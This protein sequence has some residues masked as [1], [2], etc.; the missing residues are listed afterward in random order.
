MKTVPTVDGPH[1]D[2]VL[3]GGGHSHALALRMLAMSPPPGARITLVSPESLTPYSGMLPGFVA[4]H[5]RAE[6]MHIDLA[7]LCQWA[8]VRFVRARATGLDT[9][10][11]LVLLDQGPPLPYDVLSLDIGALPD[12]CGV[13]GA[14]THA[15][16]IKPVSSFRQRWQTLLSSMHEQQG[17]MQ[18][19]IVGAGPGGT[20]MCLAVDHAL[21]GAGIAAQVRLV[22]ARTLLP[23]LA[24]GTRRAMQ[25]LLDAAQVEQVMHFP[26]T[27][28]GPH[29]IEGPDDQRLH[30]DFLLWCTGARGANWLAASP[31]ACTDDALV[32]VHDTLQSIS[33]PN[34]FAAGDCAWLDPYTLPRAG[35]YAVRQAP[36]LAANLRAALQGAPLKRYRPQHKVLALLSAG[37]RHA[38]ASRGRLSLRG[39]WVWRWKDRIDRRFMARFT[40][41][42]ARDMA[43]GPQ[44]DDHQS[45]MHCQG[46]GAKVGAQT[47]SQALNGL[48][49]VRHDEVISDYQSAEDAAVLRWPAESL[50]VQSQDYFPAFIDEPWLFGRI[51]ALHALSDL[52]AMNAQPHSALATVALAYQHPRL[53]HRDLRR[54]ME[55]A[56]LELDRVGC[57]LIGGH[58]IEGPTMAAGFMVNGRAHPDSLLHKRGAR[59]GDLLV[60]TKPLGTG[61]LLA[62]LQRGLTRGAWLDEALDSMLESHA[63]AAAL[64]AL[65]GAT[66]CTDITGFGLIGHLQEMVH[67]QPCG[68]RLHA[69]S[70][71]LLSGSLTLAQ[72]SV[73]SS[74]AAAND[75]ALQQCTVAASLAG[76]PL[77]A[78]L[79]DPQTSGGLLAAIPADTYAQ[80]MA[81]LHAAGQRA[82]GIGL[83]TDNAGIIEIQ[84]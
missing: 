50:L 77:L 53:Q 39:D 72:S 24:T 10:Q 58:T 75:L 69:H 21:S 35:V 3:V 40:E 41:L 47:L 16:P 71:P 7:A 76:D 30:T 55:G 68:A 45:V 25:R 22:D 34:I 52:H 65:H 38:V 4:G 32:R 80:C 57:A 46:C 48:Q 1:Q 60:L 23:G 54:L 73:R 67:R 44:G 56:L 70:I 8:G 84:E 78:I 66:A 64:F 13:P 9:T 79:T 27:R 42:P 29:W 82:W 19:T 61:I 81:S 15:V 63:T 31:L 43:P 18:I 6:D 11:R 62:G 14:E 26:V 17:P 36:V 5:Y 33:H 37:K 59:P 12:T 74:L 49:G 20:E 28:V 83:C 2:L 51:T